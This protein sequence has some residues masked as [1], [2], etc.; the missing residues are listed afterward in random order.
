[1]EAKKPH[2]R[3]VKALIVTGYG[4]NCEREI[5]QGCKL[6]GAEVLKIHAHDFLKQAV[7]LDNV[8][9]LLLP[10]G[11]SFG[12]ELGAGKAFANRLAYASGMKEKL[13]DFVTKGNCILGICNG[14]QLLVKLGLLPGSGTQEISLSCKDRKSVV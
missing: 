11:F 9:L 4:I 3:V 6:A 7:C 10:G 5:E 14:F 2:T 8:Q 13:Q 12:D 1:M